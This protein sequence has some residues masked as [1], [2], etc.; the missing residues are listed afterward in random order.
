[1]TSART[2]DREGAWAHLVYAGAAAQRLG[3]D[4]N[5]L[6]TAVGPTNVRIHEVSVTAEL[7]DYQQAASLG[8]TVD[9]SGMPTERQVRHR[10][11]VARAQ[12]YQHRPTE[13]N[14]LLLEAEQL[15]PDQVHGHFLTHSLVHDRLRT[16]KI[17][18]TPEL[19][20]LAQATG[21][22]AA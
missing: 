17:T 12:D 22:L 7:G 3:Q 14:Q 5:H 1:M 8:T 11:E 19:N 18:P 13:A 15:A 21:I 9:V 10:L 2:A 16:N 20:R 6:W 4:A